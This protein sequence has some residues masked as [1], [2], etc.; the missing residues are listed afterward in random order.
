MGLFAQ[1]VRGDTLPHPRARFR[2][3]PGSLAGRLARSGMTR[4][5]LLRLTTFLFA[6]LLTLQAAFAAP[7]ILRRGNTV[8]PDSLDPQKSSLDYTIAIT[9]D[10]LL[11]LVQ[12]DARFE[13]VAGAA[14]R[15]TVSADGLVYTFV[16]RQGLK[17]SDGVPLTADDAVFALRRLVTPQTAS[18]SAYLAFKIK[19]ARDV[20]AGKL[21]P[22][23]LGVRAV[24]ART[25]EITLIA[26]NPL[27]LNMLAE[28][29]FA[30]LPRHAIEKHQAKWTRPGLM[31]A[32]G[33][34]KLAA[35]RAG[36]H[37]QLTKNAAF[38]DARNVAID[39]VFYYPTD[40]D[41]AALRRFRAGE[42][43]LNLRFTS[44][45]LDW[46]KRNQPQAVRIAPAAWGTRIAI[47]MKA[48][49][50]AYL[51]VRRAIALAIDREAI[52]EKILRT[53]ETAAYGIMPP[54]A[55]GYAG[56]KMDFAGKPMAARLDEARAL[57]K[58]AG[59]SAAKPLS[60]DLCQR[61]G[62]ANRRV[63][64]ALQNMLAAAGIKVSLKFS[65]VARYYD[66]LRKGDC[67]I[68]V[69]GLAWPPDPALFLGDLQSGSPQNYSFYRKPTYDAALVAAGKMADLGPRYA[70]FAAAE[71]MVLADFVSIPLYFNAY[72]AIVAPHVKGFE[73]NGRDLHPTRLLRI[74][75]EQA[76]GGKQAR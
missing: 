68:A 76:G 56:A 22:E 36:D 42:L 20:Q 50:F 46:L 40:D 38:Y 41:A 63:G 24:D 59:F 21:K 13:P 64:V 3:P 19:N 74:E 67:E 26:P 4:T 17:W 37:V 70:A 10:M 51:R 15:W 28:P 52:V 66:E 71:A 54:V 72:T 7:S 49:R 53:G 75:K 62:P 30:P 27:F 34:Y 61:T 14:E 47:N 44:T 18:P 35:W 60:F 32:S 55:P 33:A 1:I 9:G 48:S 69:I 25:V 73:M 45:E 8:E 23:Q 29:Y 65:D 6:G 16:L 2:Q 43:D 11:S 5:A 57:L 31:P 12:G 58:A 39:Q